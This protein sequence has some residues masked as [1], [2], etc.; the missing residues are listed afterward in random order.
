MYVIN[1]LPVRVGSY[2][3]RSIVME[4]CFRWITFGRGGESLPTASDCSAIDAVCGSYNPVYIHL[5]YSSWIWK[6]SR[7]INLTTFKDK[8]VGYCNLKTFKNTQGNILYEVSANYLYS[9]VHYKLSCNTHHWSP[10]Y[11]LYWTRYLS[12][13][14]HFCKPQISS[15]QRH[16]DAEQFSC[17]SLAPLKCQI[18]HIQ[19]LTKNL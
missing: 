11:L 18:T 12:R 17:H 10:P 1:C 4:L 9:T 2:E 7:T 13:Q 6:Q 5:L 8:L 14:A 15:D 16:I 3:G 19:R